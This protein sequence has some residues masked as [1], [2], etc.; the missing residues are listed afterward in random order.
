MDDMKQGMKKKIIILCGPTGI[1]KTRLAIDLARTFDGEIIGADSMQIYRYMDIGT[2]KPDV[3]E[4]RMAP[5]HLIDFVPP[6]HPFDAGQYIEHADAVI[7]SL[8]DR[9]KLPIVAG[10]T[11]FYIKAL[12]HGLF[13]ERTADALVIQRLENELKE[14]GAAALHGRLVALD[15][16]AAEKIHP[17]DTFRVIR[18]LEVV[19]VTGR[20]ISSHRQDHGFSEERYDALTFCLYMERSLLYKR[21]DQRVDLMIDQG[22][23]DEVKGLLERGYACDLKSMQSIGYRHLCD[24]LTCGVSWDETIRLMKRDTRRYAKRQFTW[25]RNQKET[26]WLEPHE[27]DRAKQLVV[28]FLAHRNH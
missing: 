18:A 6:D 22:F 21:I 4:R 5:H 14:K 10:G 23:L 11:G 13:R 28:E 2:A 16:D 27:T 26:V 9:D 7:A 19:E 12:L 15:P 8:L 24:H 17:N 1:G 20:T 25:F 3:M